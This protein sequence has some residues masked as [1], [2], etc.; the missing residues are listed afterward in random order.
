VAGREGRNNHGHNI[1]IAG[2]KY[3]FIDVQTEC[4]KSTTKKQSNNSNNKQMDEFAME[5]SKK[6][7]TRNSYAV[8]VRQ[9]Y[10]LK[11]SPCS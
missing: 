10:P 8:T 9:G 11:E 1:Y 2:S 4:G 6:M 5:N 7:T 3:K